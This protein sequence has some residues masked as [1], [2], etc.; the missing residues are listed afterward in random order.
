MYG[1]TIRFG[2]RLRA[3]RLSRGLTQ[4]QLAHQLGMDRSFMSDVERGKKAIT[5]TYLAKIAD[6]MDLTVGEL[7]D[8]V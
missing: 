6:G 1:I 7:L 2:L 4:L 5:L 8:G 3:L